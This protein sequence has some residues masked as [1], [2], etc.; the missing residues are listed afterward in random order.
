MDATTLV[1]I[2][3]M[4][5]VTETSSEFVKYDGLGACLK[6]KR[7][8]EKLKDGRK[9]I[10]GPSMAELDADGNI[11]GELALR[12]TE[13]LEYLLG[14]TA[15]GT[16]HTHDGTDFSGHWVTLVC[17][18]DAT[19]SPGVVDL[20]LQGVHNLP[21]KPM[22]AESMGT[23]IHKILPSDAFND[24]VGEHPTESGTNQRER[25][26][27]DGN[28]L[29]SGTVHERGESD[30]DE[31]EPID[32]LTINTPDLQISSP[33]QHV[34]G[35]RGNEH[36][37]MD[38][39]IASSTFNEAFD[40]TSTQIG[41][42]NLSLAA[43]ALSDEYHTNI[44]PIQRDEIQFPRLLPKQMPEDSLGAIKSNLYKKTNPSNT[45]GSSRRGK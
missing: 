40:D 3:T 36:T 4:F 2:I 19:F 22:A 27:G 13:Q 26:E 32:E 28:S 29:E 20:S 10:C 35:N 30:V 44:R 37:D 14:G 38:R 33:A 7:A 1:T 18:V 12:S 21:T 5:I 9:A 11:F 34:A 25:K 8:I 15:I 45:G 6:D 42:E 43:S 17:D 31:A 16:A 24:F 41:G 23:E 39:S